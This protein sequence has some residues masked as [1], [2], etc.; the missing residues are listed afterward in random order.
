MN[1]VNLAEYDLETAIMKRLR[2]TRAVEP[3][4]WGMHFIYR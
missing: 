2:T 4:E 1:V 3:F